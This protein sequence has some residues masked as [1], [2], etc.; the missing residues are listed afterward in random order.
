MANILLVVDSPI[1]SNALTRLLSTA[2]YMVRTAGDGLVA[3]SALRVFAPDLVLMDVRLP[4]LDGIQLCKAIRR[5]DDF[6][7]LPIVMLSG[8]STAT[9]I[10]QALGAGANDYLV[11]P[12]DDTTLLAVL[13]RH[14]LV[15]ET[16]PSPRG[17]QQE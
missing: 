15:A 2:G 4:H 9:D 7:M 13:D 11:K 17:R 5:L 1:V 10:Q 3:L 6:K 14:L 8:L 12:V 16:P